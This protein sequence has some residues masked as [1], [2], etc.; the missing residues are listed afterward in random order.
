VLLHA[1]TFEAK[2]ATPE[3]NDELERDSRERCGRLV[4]TASWR[5]WVGG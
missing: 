2:R 4:K 1:R 5:G 3:K